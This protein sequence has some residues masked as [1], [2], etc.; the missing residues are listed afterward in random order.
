MAEEK[1]RDP[2]LWVLL[3]ED[4]A[5]YQYDQEP[6]VACLTREAAEAQREPEAGERP[7]TMYVPVERMLRVRDV[8][9]EIGRKWLSEEGRAAIGLIQQVLDGD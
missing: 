1:R 2:N 9:E 4:P 7:P 3:P 5:D 8:V 6:L